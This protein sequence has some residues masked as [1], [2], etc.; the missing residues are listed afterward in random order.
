MFSASH[1][2]LDD[3]AEDPVS[4][5][6]A[7]APTLAPPV[8]TSSGQDCPAGDALLSD[9]CVQ[10]SVLLSGLRAAQVSTGSVFVIFQLKIFS[11]FHYASFF[12]PPRSVKVCIPLLPK[13]RESASWLL[14]SGW[15]HL[16]QE[17]AGD[18]RRGRRPAG[19]SISLCS[20]LALQ[21]DVQPALLGSLPDR[22]EGGNRGSRGP[23]PASTYG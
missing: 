12:V 9:L 14:I 1:S 6:T 4:G 16:D 23:R 17:H 20:P 2:G 15:V 8:S 7:A 3:S 11:T 10:G 5:A 19:V 18:G 13:H 22:L 21:E